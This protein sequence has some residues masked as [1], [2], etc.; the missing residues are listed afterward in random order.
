MW[1]QIQRNESSGWM[2]V[3]ST[4]AGLLCVVGLPVVVLPLA[5][6]RPVHTAAVT[7]NM[8]IPVPAPILPA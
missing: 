1:I 2:R 3:R 8:G 4:L 5:D 6:V 7:G